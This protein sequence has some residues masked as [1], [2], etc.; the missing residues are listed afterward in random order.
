MLA[1]LTSQHTHCSAA[2]CQEG[3]LVR[4]RKLAEI[5]EDTKT[6]LL[7]CTDPS[8]SFQSI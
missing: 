3:E 8:V 6:K 2:L 5:I 4:L 1:W 7:G